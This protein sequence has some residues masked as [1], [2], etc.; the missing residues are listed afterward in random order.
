MAINEVVLVGACRTAIG[1]Y[2]KSLADVPANT[3]AEIAGAEA[4]KR[5]GVAPEIIDEIVSG[6]IY[7]HGNGSLPARIIG[8]RLG[9]PDRSG[10]TNINQNCASGMR[11]L[12][13]AAMGLMLGRTETALVIGVDTMSRIPYLLPKARWGYRMGAGNL[14]DPLLEDGLYCTLAQGHMGLTAENV[15]ARFGITRE[16]CDHLA[17]ISQTRALRAIGEG[18][19]KR[20]IAPVEIKGRKGVTIFDTDEHPNAKTTLEI[21]AKLKPAFKE[22]GVVT[23]GN[24]SGINDAAAAAILMTKQKAKELGLKPLMKLLGV[25][26]EGV[27]PEVMG[28]GPAVAIP[29]VLKQCGIKYQDIDYWEIN[30]AFAPQVIGSCR[31]LKEQSG[32]EVNFGDAEHDGNVNNNGSGIALGHPVGCTALRIIVSLYYEL[33]R[34]GKTTGG[35]SLCV[36]G[37]PGMASLWTRDI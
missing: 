34:L 28:L 1:S 19:F 22:G 2:G 4:I 17:M 23:A 30:E 25:T 10:A 14:V 9:L 31:M 7:V 12:D 26:V 20:E 21:L 27:A 36:G 6:S 24:A 33:E 35:A 18:R 13:V 37:G 29:K 11:A 8:K 5:A 3:L 15:A 16:E 32:I